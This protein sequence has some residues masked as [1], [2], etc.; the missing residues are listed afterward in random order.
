M[1][2]H[3]QTGFRTR[4]KIYRMFLGYSYWVV[5]ITVMPGIFIV[6]LDTYGSV[7]DNNYYEFHEKYKVP[8]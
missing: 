6:S 2:P 8:M 1:V 5:L 7:S 4:G 3:S